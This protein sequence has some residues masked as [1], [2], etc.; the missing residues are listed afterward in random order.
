MARGPPSLACQILRSKTG[1]V[2]PPLSATRANPLASPRDCD[3][4]Q[5]FLTNFCELRTGVFQALPFMP[6]S[7]NAPSLISNGANR[8]VL[9][10]A[11]AIFCVFLRKRRIPWSRPASQRFW[12]EPILTSTAQTNSKC[13]GG[14]GGKLR[15]SEAPSTQAAGMADA[16]FDRPLVPAR[17][18]RQILASANLTTRVQKAVGA[19]DCHR[20]R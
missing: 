2:P 16:S 15:L 4:R 18:R 19:S 20:I 8:C 12:L 7:G 13:A 11:E 6:S 3:P 1:V 10:H 9:A 5:P 14:R 17:S